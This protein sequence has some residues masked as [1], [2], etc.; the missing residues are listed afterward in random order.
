MEFFENWLLPSLS[1]PVTSHLIYNHSCSL[2][3]K[4]TGLFGAF[5]ISSGCFFFLEHSSSPREPQISRS[6]SPQLF[7]KT[8]LVSLITFSPVFL[9]C[10]PY[11]VHPNL[12]CTNHYYLSLY[13]FI[14]DKVFLALLYLQ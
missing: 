13:S 7:H 4:H 5:K 8:L 2:F 11:L 10:F 3:A 12:T 6:S 14:A 9:S 1:T